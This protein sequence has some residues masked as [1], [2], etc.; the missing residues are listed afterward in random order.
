[1]GVEVA[2]T[3]LLST[4]I[5]L[6]MIELKTFGTSTRRLHIVRM[7]KTTAMLLNTGGSST[8]WVGLSR[9]KLFAQSM[10]Q[11]LDGD[12]GKPQPQRL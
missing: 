7:Q 3:T 12:R 1:M 6:T 8:V 10:G 2:T 11:K 4:M 9:E 5:V